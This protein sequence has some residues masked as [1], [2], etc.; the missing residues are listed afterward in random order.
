M[1]CTDQSAPSVMNEGLGRNLL[2]RAVAV[3]Q[4]ERMTYRVTSWGSRTTWPWESPHWRP[5]GT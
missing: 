4:T 3:S 5:T 2:M 1:R